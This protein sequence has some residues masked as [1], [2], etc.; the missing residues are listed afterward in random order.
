MSVSFGCKKNR[1]ARGRRVTSNY[2]FPLRLGDMLLKLNGKLNLTHKHS[3]LVLT[4]RKA[5]MT[6][7]DMSPVSTTR[8]AMTL[9]MIFSLSEVDLAAS[10]VRLTC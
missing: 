3:R 2:Q 10:T 5:D 8:S 7:T 4:Q 9:I 1:N 6:Q